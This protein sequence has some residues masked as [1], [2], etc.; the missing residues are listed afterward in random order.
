L[1]LGWQW[2]TSGELLAEKRRLC[3]AA[4]G[5]AQSLSE[6]NLSGQ[7]QLHRDHAINI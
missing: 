6:T 7:S 3:W 2:A 5:A 1:E 4:L